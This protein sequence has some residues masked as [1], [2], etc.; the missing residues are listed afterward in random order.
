MKPEPTPGPDTLIMH[1]AEERHK[2]HGA[3]APPLFQNSTFTFPDCEEFATRSS[4]MR[5]VSGGDGQRF[6]YT[7]VSNPTTSILEQKIAIL[8]KAES[9]RAFGSGMA[10][11]LGG[12]SLVRPLGRSHRHHRHGLRPDADILHVLPAALRD[13]DDVRARHRGRSLPQGPATEHEAPLCRIAVEPDLRSS[14]SRRRRRVGEV[15]GHRDGHR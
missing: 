2:L 9:A 11:H 5:G 10:A 4:A 7:R 6:D 12:D 8:E 1:H 15:A 3:A 14:G 13:R